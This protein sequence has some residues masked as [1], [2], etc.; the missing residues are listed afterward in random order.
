MIAWFE[1]KC[2]DLRICIDESSTTCSFDDDNGDNGDD[3]DDCDLQIPLECLE[4]ASVK[5]KAQSCQGN[6]INARLKQRGNE[7]K[8]QSFLLLLLLIA[9]KDDGHEVTV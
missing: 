9:E 8:G 5:A 7:R 3:D 6:V 1:L 4:S 2:T